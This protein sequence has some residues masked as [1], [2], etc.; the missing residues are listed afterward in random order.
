MERQEA[1]LRRFDLP[2]RCPGV[3][4]GRVAAAMALD[5]KVLGETI[6][7]VLLEDVGRAVVRSDVP[8]AL[9]QSVLQDLSRQLG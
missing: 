5:K 6:R 3:D 9:V 1:L 8:Q 4:P 7:W 2:L